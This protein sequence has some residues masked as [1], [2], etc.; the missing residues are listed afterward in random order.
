MTAYTLN[1]ADLAPTLYAMSHGATELNPLMQN[2]HV[3]VLY[4]TILTGLAI[5]W[6]SRQETHLARDGMKFCAA[7]YAAVNIWHILNF[8]AG[9]AA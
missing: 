5:W 8:A 9:W 2:I 1:L 6:L 4:T 7:V 3:M